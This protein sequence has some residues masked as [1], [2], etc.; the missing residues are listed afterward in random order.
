M[1][2]EE[3]ETIVVSTTLAQAEHPA[4]T[5]VAR[6]VE[7]F[8]TD[9]KAQ[10]GK[11]IWLFGGGVLFRS[12]LEVGLVD[13]VEVGVIPV[14]LGQGIALLPGLEGT[15]KLRLHSMEEWPTSGIV[16]LKYDVDNASQAS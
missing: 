1:G 3:M 2:F 15:A 11:D 10:A 9:L 14:L 4:V 12:L 13:R 5:I 16:L 7:T 6:G 8:V